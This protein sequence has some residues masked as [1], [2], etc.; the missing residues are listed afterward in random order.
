MQENRIVKI[1]G[2]EHKKETKKVSKGK[3]RGQKK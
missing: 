3:T 1:D 2:F